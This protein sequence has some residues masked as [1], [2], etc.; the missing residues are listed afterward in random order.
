MAYDLD[1]QEKLEAIKSWWHAYGNLVTT[2]ALAILVGIAGMQAW[3][4]YRGQQAAAASTLYQQLDTADH[5]SEPKKVQDIAKNIVAKYASTPYAAMAALRAAK[6]SA[7]ANDYTSTKQSL[8]W[9]IDNAKEDEMRDV[10]RLRFAGVLLDEKKYDDALTQLNA[11]HAAEFEGLYADLKGDVLVAQNKRA[12][13]RAA[14]Q[15]ALDKSDI[16]SPYR[17]MIQVK[18]DALGDAK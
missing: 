8:Q 7:T 12:D 18:L 14:Y 3:R 16:R 10:A 4:Y 1:E 6:S 17:P 15:V 9:V 2:A 11:K 13:A 5:M